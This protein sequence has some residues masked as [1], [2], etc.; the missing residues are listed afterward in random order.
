M[1]I[2]SLALVACTANAAPAPRHKVIDAGAGWRHACALLD[3]GT[4]RCWGDGDSGAIGDGMGEQRSRPTPV[5]AGENVTRGTTGTPLTDAIGLAVSTNG[6][7]ALIKGGTV[8][9]WGGA[10]SPRTI[11]GVDHAVEIAAGLAFTCARIDDGSVRCWGGVTPKGTIAV[12]AISQLPKVAKLAIGDSNPCAVLADGGVACWAADR[13]THAARVDG[14]TAAVDAWATSDRGGC[15]RDAA[16]AI[17]CWG[18]GKAPKGSLA[19]ASWGDREHCTVD[20]RGDATCTGRPVHLSGVRKTASGGTVSCAVMTSG[21]LRC[22]GS[23]DYGQLG[24]GGGTKRTTPARVLN[25]AKADALWVGTGT[26][27]R[28]AGHVKCWGAD[29]DAVLGFEGPPYYA[30][31]PVA[32][33]ALDTA[34]QVDI[35]DGQGCGLGSRGL[36]CWTKDTRGVPTPV[37]DTSTVR[38]VAVA[39]AHACARLDDGTAICWGDSLAVLGRGGTVPDPE[40]GPYGPAPVKGLTDVAQLSAGTATTCA[41][42]T[43]GKIRC[44]GAAGV[45][46]DGSRVSTTAVTTPTTV[47]GITDATFVAVNTRGSEACAIKKDRTIACWGHEIY[48]EFGD[49]D[50]E[51]DYV[52]RLVP[53]SARGIKD[54]I[55]LAIGDGDTCVLVDGGAVQCLGGNQYGE[56]GDGTT[57]VRV[58]PRAVMT[59]AVEIGAHDNTMC[60][61]KRDGSVWCWGRGDFGAT[62]DGMPNER[63]APYPVPFD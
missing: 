62:G 36:A 6:A 52:D 4:V 57:E 25:I 51:Q 40:S 11:A 54:V 39:Q 20:D 37:P 24:D 55:G 30:D 42:L 53:V 45:L 63:A 9:C 27:A 23:T 31:T 47:K 44:W 56:V 14:I 16:G 21:E 13:K 49:W 32:F 7:C 33:A 19:F 43:T 46:G 38:E 22:W 48:G 2:L 8:R 1:R 17:A 35:A 29:G 10:W 5:I 3:D 28:D 26:C 18:N 58:K 34:T 59:D 61:R 60:A 15:A 50:K 12:T 41:R